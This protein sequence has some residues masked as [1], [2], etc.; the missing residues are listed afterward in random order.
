MRTHTPMPKKVALY[1]P[2]VSERAMLEVIV[3]AKKDNMPALTKSMRRA[4]LFAWNM[5]A[6]LTFLLYKI[7][8]VKNKT[9]DSM[10]LKGKAHQTAISH[11][12][13]MILVRIR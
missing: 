4:N 7:S 6:F 13:L 9:H 3:V 10:I 12:V 2:K 11:V 5:A 1:S 8:K